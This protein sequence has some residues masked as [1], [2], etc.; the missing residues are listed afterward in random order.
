MLSASRQSFLRHAA[1]IALAAFAL[2]AAPGARATGPRL[3]AQAWLLVDHLSG[4]VLLEHNADRA[5]PPA[6][7][8]KLMTAYLVFE[9]LRAGELKLADRVQI[10]PRA[11]TMRPSRVPLTVGDRVPV[12]QLLKAMIVRSAN[13]AAVAL[14]ERVAGSE[15]NFVGWMNA[16][17]RAWG[18]R[19][20]HFANATG[21]DA[22]GHLSS[23]R[24]MSRLTSALLRDFPDYYAW[25]GIKQF[26][27]N[28]TNL[29]NSNPL[30]WRDAQI[31][32]VKTGVTGQA[33]YCLIASAKRNDMR[34]IATVLGARH[35]GGRSDAVTRLLDY[36]FRHFETR[37]LYA[38]DRPATQVRVWR[39]QT[40]LLPLGVTENVYI[41]L[42]RGW[43]DKLRTRLSL[44]PVLEA[45]IQRGQRLGRLGLIVDE[46]PIG[47]YP[48]I[49]LQE[50]GAGGFFQRTLDSVRL[51][52][53]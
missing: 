16:R 22:P 50:I 26:A 19:Q 20:T 5:L 9:R 28:G 23:A 41:T 49:A 10:S 48:L 39:G 29:Y 32:G 6:S 21:L 46:Q 18:L 43:H 2:L 17:A 11:A 38:T 24:D 33:G 14:A 34:L 44:P 51:T 47:E 8:T 36:G 52:F 42:P 37:L 13:D 3:D 15:T 53:H 31:D 1:L 27:F 30:L 45:P 12:E 4:S 25:F 7:L 40:P 35:A